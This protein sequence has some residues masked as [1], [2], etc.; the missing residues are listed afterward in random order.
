MAIIVTNGAGGPVHNMKVDKTDRAL[1]RSITESE[2]THATEDGD[3]FNINTGS[4]TLTGTT[5]SAVL[6]V[7]NVSSDFILVIDAIAM[8][9]DAPSTSF[10]NNVQLK[11]I[12]GPTGGDI[13]SGATD[14]SM[15]A[16]R[17]EASSK[18]MSDFDVYMGS[19]GESMTGGSDAALF[20]QNGQGRAYFTVGWTVEKNQ[21]IGLKCTPNVNGGG[22]AAC[23]FAF[24][25]HLKDPDLI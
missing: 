9:V 24:I 13:V 20:W 16:N 5:E 14:A 4:I 23:Y 8:G 12:S 11:F 18:T 2:A 6:Y 21:S 10:D 25:C 17:S 7:K 22:T 1:T 3:A 15:I 19:N